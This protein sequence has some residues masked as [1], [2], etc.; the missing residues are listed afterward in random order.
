M[1]S[2]NSSETTSGVTSPRGI[3]DKELDSKADNIPFF[4]IV[5]VGDASVGK[6]AVIGAIGGKSNP[7]KTK[8]TQE[9]VITNFG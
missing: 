2:C 5:V 9:P 3:S 4:K 1:G 7:L 6:S 8:P